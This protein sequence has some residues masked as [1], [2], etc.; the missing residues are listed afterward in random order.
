M[1]IADATTTHVAYAAY[2]DRASGSSSRRP[3]S[4]AK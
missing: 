2:I 4:T 1:R 3:R